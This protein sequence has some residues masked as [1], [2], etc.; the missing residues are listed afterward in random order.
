VRAVYRDAAHR[1]SA[2]VSA[3]WTADDG[4]LGAVL[5]GIEVRGRR[6][7]G[8]ASKLLK[9]VLADADA[10]GVTLTLQVARVSGPGRLAEA[11]LRAWYRRH[12]FTDHFSTGMS[13]EP[14]QRNC[15]PERR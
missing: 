10:E 2:R 12:G 7:N 5:T 13:R 11:E 8:Y 1:A 6:G 3:V 15:T 4:S 14:Q 9:R